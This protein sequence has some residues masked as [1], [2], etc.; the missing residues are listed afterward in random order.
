M[1]GLFGKLAGKV[2]NLFRKKPAISEARRR[3]QETGDYGHRGIA[4]RTDDFAGYDVSPENLAKRELLGKETAEG[5]LDGEPLFVHSSNVAMMQWF[6]DTNQLMVEYHGGG[7]YLYDNVSETEAIAFLQAWSKG[8][9][10]WDYLRVR[11]S[12]TA[13]KKPYSRLK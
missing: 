4:K 8:G 2:R 9:A 13:H 11:G 7:T 10:V 5:F 3:M 1:A 12:R 6:K